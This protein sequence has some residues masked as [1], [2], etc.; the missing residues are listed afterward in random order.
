MCLDV[1]HKHNQLIFQGNNV[2]HLIINAMLLSYCTGKIMLLAISKSDLWFRFAGG[3]MKNQKCET[4]ILN[5]L[6]TSRDVA[7]VNIPHLNYY[8]HVIEISFRFLRS[9]GI[10]CYNCFPYFLSLNCKKCI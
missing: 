9:S 4:L 8:W 2:K 1:S 7:D 3:K 6:S 5:G 10:L